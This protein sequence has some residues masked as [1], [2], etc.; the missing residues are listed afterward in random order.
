MLRS[1]YLELLIILIKILSILNKS[2]A[3]ITEINTNEWPIGIYK[4]IEVI[5][6]IFT[7]NNR[8]KLKASNYQKYCNHYLIRHIL[9][10]GV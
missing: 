7:L 3:Q 9:C 10:Q 8:L 2:N 5:V 4:L 6:K 1:L